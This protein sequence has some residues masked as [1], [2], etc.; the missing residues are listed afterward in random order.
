[1]FK[2]GKLLTNDDHEKKISAIKR[3]NNTDY[4]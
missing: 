4:F 1:M 3:I 2:T